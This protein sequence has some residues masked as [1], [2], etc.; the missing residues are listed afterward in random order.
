MKVLT[1][2]MMACTKKQCMGKG[3]PLAVECSNFETLNQEFN[4]EFT[5]N[6]YPKLDWKGIM[7]MAQKFNIPISADVTTHSL[8][9]EK[10]LKSLH[11]LLC[12]FKVIT[13]SLQCPNCQ[14]V[15][16]IDKGIPNMLLREDEIY[17]DI[18]E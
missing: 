9:D 13:G 3:F 2:N 17:Q 4:V 5:K 12:N 15:Y 11:H 1:H 7:E 8:K 18:R 10:F 6:I 14:R 16:P